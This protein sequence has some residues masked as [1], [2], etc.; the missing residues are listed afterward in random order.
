MIK[1]L[2]CMLTLCLAAGSIYAE[3]EKTLAEDSLKLAQEKIRIKTENHSWVK[4]SSKS[5]NG[6][7]NLASQIKG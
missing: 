4:L 3:K 7:E 5:M 1:K 2:S 6:R